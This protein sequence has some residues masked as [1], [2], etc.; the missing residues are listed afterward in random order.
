MK[1]DFVENISSRLDE[2]I[3]RGRHLVEDEDLALRAEEMMEKAETT[4]R[5]Y[6]LRSVAAGLL[7]GYIIGKLFSSDH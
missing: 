1:D 4:I 2:A 3:E 5:K 7:A 6:P